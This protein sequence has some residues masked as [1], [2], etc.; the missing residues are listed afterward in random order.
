MAAQP[1]AVVVI[2]KRKRVEIDEGHGGGAW[3][4][5]YADFVTAMM[6][7]FLVMWLLNATT[8]QQ[9]QGLADY[10][11]PVVP[12]NL[13]SGGG[14]GVLSGDS[15]VSEQRLPHQ[16]PGVSGHLRADSGPA[17]DVS[18]PAAAARATGEAVD[19][20]G[21]DRTPSHARPA[22]DAAAA[23]DGRAAGE[24]SLRKVAQQLSARGGESMTMKRLMRHVVT[25][26]TDKGLVI[27]L[28]D[29]PGSPLFKHDTEVPT[30]TA[31]QIAAMISE[32]LDLATNPIAVEGHVRSYPITL[33]D[34]PAWRLSAARA[35]EIRA[36]LAR[37][38]L[39]W[40]RFARVSGHADRAP[41]TANP[42][43]Q[44]NNRIEVILL[45][46]DR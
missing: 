5:A 45:R 27:E 14:D 26:I 8:E 20:N 43:E 9:R 3:K 30:E 42:V 12:I 41:V 38:R 6:A 15:V 23:A 10:F 18:Q 35:Q 40:D 1:N 7:F 19:E 29:I 16:G 34:N 46:A 25:R 21:N 31:R 39:S 22:S 28:F 13:I 17:A 24:E 2:N 44:R 11:N 4:I 37:G 33:I 36:L 32:V